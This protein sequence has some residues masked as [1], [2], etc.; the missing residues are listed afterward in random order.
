MSS[1]KRNTT[2]SIKQ[3]EKRKQNIEQARIL[4]FIDLVLVMVPFV[5]LIFRDLSLS[6]VFYD[7]NWALAACILFGQTIARLA[8]GVA[9][10]KIK[11]WYEVVLVIILFFACTMFG[12]YVYTQLD[13]SESELPSPGWAFFQIILF[14][15]SVACFRIF[16]TLGQRML[17][18]K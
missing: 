18:E 9:K 1:T 6:K 12:T 17:D 2:I 13:V 5:F 7:P 8:S 11:R 3:A 16:G 10:K 4:I 15:V 14:V